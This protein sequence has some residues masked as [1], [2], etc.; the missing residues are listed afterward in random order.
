MSK[1]RLI[2]CGNLSS[3]SPGF[4]LVELLVVIAIIGI[5]IALL[6]PA[7]QAARET[8]R[9]L[10]C[11]NNLKQIGE[12]AQNHISTHKRLPT[13]GWTCAFIGNPDRGAGRNQTGGWMF[14][15]LP[16]MEQKQTYMM[17]AGKTGAARSNAAI[18]MIQMPITT[19]NC[20][21]RRPSILFPIPATGGGFNNY[22]MGSGSLTTGPLTLV[23]RSDYAANG[24]TT[25]LDPNGDDGFGYNG[26]P[27]TGSNPIFNTIATKARG[28]IFSGSLIRLIDI[29]DG[30]SHTIMVGEKYLNR[31][32]Y[33]SG[34]DGADNENMYIGDNP[35]IT[36]FTG[37]EQE[38]LPPQ[39]DR[40][41]YANV[42]LFGSAHPASINCVMCDGSVHSITYEVDGIMFSRLGSRNDKKG[43]SSEVY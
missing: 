37:T 42:D 22:K 3:E 11:S 36:R 10:S 40:A 18:A 30:T 16:Y 23:A 39:R 24:G 19:M 17:Q 26:D 13:G 32:S 14:N 28:V 35:D 43:V 1:H 9:R 20:P 2:R 21:T 6:L 25:H 4:T 15:I 33:Y 12:A 29:P 41:G 8:G 7:I 38:T 34:L 5:L 31:D 27:G